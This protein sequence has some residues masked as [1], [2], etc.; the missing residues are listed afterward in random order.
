MSLTRRQ[1][2]AAAAALTGGAALV[3]AAGV[4]GTAWRWWDQAPGAGYRNVSPD[5]ARF[6][7]ALAEAVFPA[8]GQPALG[9]AEA[10]VAHY[11]DEVL[12]GMAPAQRNLIRLAAHALDNLARTSTG[13]ALSD[14]P[15][16]AATA[17]LRAWLAHPRPEI[18][19]LAQSFYLFVTM[20][21][22]AHPDV[23][24]LLVPSFSCGFG[25]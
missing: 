2:L 23:A 3:G 22:L 19:G 4:A 21:Y 20:A 17:V 5:E 25:P 15:T 13:H 6:F 9:G 11:L 16:P 12:Q 1:L 7:D 18:R 24:P 10:G 8:G 14:L